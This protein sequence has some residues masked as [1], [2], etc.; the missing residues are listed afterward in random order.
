[1]ASYMG[2]SFES[3]SKSAAS[4]GIGNCKPFKISVVMLGTA[5]PEFIE[6][7]SSRLT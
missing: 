5:D 7:K 4:L 6:A 1:M 3:K 2:C